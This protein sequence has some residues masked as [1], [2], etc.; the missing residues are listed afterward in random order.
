MAA[1]TEVGRFITDDAGNRVAVILDLDEYH[2]LLEAV[3]ELEDICAYDEAKASKDEAI[4]FVQAIR[5]LEQG[6][7]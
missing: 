5:D 7:R 2:K 1:M 4:P 6:R 3:E